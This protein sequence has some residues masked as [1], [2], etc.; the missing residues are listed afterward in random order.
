MRK[1][2][3]VSLLLALC[4]LMSLVLSACEPAAETSQPPDATASQPGGDHIVPPQVVES[5]FEGTGTNGNYQYSGKFYADYSTLEEA[6]MAAHALAVEIAGE[7]IT[8]LKN[9]NNALPLSGDETKVTLLG[10][11][12]ARMVR[13]GFG[14][15]SGGGSAIGNLLGEA[16]EAAGYSVNPKT[17]ELYTK[18]VSQMV[19]DRI[20]ELGM[21]SYGPSITNTYA[22]YNDAAIL[23]FSRTGAENYDLATNNVPGHANEDDHQL[24]L[25]DNERALVMHAKEHFSKVIVLINSSNIMQIPE[26]AEPKTDSNMGVDAILWVGSVGQDGTTAIAHILNGDITPSGHTVDLWEKDF[27]K[28]PTFTNFGPNTQNKD[29]S[30]NRMDT[31]YYDKNGEPTKFANLEYREGIY[32]GYKYYETLYADAEEGAK[33]AA[34]ENVLYPF[35]YG[36]SYTDFQWEL[37]GV[38]E[39]ETISAANETVTLR[40][41]VTNTGN[42]VG[43]DVVQVYFNPPY[44][45]GGIEKAAANLAGFAKTGLLQPGQSEVVTISFV[46]QDMASF[47]WNDA[48]GNGFSGYELEEGDYIISAKRNSHDE[49]LS[50]TRTVASGIQCKTDLVTGREIKPVFTGSFSSVNDSLLN[51]MISRADGLKQPAPA[52]LADRTLDDAT[53]ADYESQAEYYSYQ[54][55]ETDPWYVSTLPSSWNQAISADQPLVITLADMAGVP[56]NEPVINDSNEVVL[57]TDADSQKWEEFMNQFTWEELCSLPANPDNVVERMGAIAVRVPRGGTTPA[58][59]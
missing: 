12:T 6:Q 35:G 7:G 14:S 9:E 30:G 51:N 31:L 56:Y 50:V 22:S 41:K 39:S 43:K 13:S 17:V 40:V 49:V 45:S 2:K 57:A 1:K 42:V 36:L 18:E 19:E 25:D 28:S 3:L 48:N 20:Y 21:D 32:L 24:M 59:T 54:D 46:A 26:L 53:L 10:I 38:K 15:G 34:Y 58:P 23:T 27:T 4:M 37:D 5:L 33:D 8:L 44:T 55:K 47:D 29:S 16:L 52:T 11:R